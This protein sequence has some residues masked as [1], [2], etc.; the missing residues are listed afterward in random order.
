[1]EDQQGGN[2]F[3]VVAEQGGFIVA[4]EKITVGVTGSSGAVGEPPLRGSGAL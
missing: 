1:M 4:E 2:S 3:I